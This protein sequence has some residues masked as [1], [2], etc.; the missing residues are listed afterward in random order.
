M[1]V[2]LLRKNPKELLVYIRKNIPEGFSVYYEKDKFMYVVHKDI[3]NTAKPLLLAH[4]DTVDN[5]TIDFALKPIV[6]GNTPKG[7]VIST[8]PNELYRCL[9]G[10]DRCGVWIMLQ[11]LKSNPKDYKFLFT[12]EEES[13]GGGGD[14]FVKSKY[15][16]ENHWTAYVSLDRR[17]PLGTQE[18]ALYGYNNRELTEFF[19]SL[20]YSI[21][22]GSFTDCMT[23]SMAGK[24]ACINLSVGYDNEHS[25]NEVVYTNC[26]VN[27]YD[28]LK[29]PKVINY[30]TATNYLQQDDYHNDAM[31]SYGWSTKSSDGLVEP[32]LCDCCG[33]HLPLYND[34]GYQVCIECIGL[35]KDW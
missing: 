4:L 3:K 26:M 30:L 17:S 19:E 29:S 31:W 33:T 23:L 2:S 1:L 15:Y 20:D 27:T 24:L 5:D 9:G 10:D 21:A 28:T 18:V 34:D 11:L 12:F 8:E 25:H 7:Q 35:L 14:A 6:I 13:G 16:N 22:D 32:V